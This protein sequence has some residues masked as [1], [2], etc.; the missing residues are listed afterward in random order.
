VREDG[1]IVSREGWR[2]KV[3]NRE[4]WEKFLGR[5]RYRCILLMATE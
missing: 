3:Y 4:E 1:R 5:A 2:D